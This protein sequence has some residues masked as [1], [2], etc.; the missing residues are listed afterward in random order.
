MSS[1][2]VYTFC[3]C[4]SLQTLD[5]DMYDKVQGYFTTLAR[6]EL[7]C[8]GLT[9]ECFMKILTDSCT[10]IMTTLRMVRGLYEYVLTRLMYGKKALLYARVFSNMWRARHVCL[11]CVG[12]PRL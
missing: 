9:Q 8:C 5:G 6:S 10:N 11:L 2:Y 4:V 1:P 7:E 3:H 12:E